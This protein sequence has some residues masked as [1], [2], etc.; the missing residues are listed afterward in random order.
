MEDLE[1]FHR[2]W[3]TAN[4][5][6]R[7]CLTWFVFPRCQN[8]SLT[9][10][11]ICWP[12]QTRLSRTHLRESN[13]V[14]VTA[15]VSRAGI[16]LLSSARRGGQEGKWKLLHLLLAIAQ[17]KHSSENEAAA[18]TWQQEG[19]PPPDITLNP[20]D[21]TPSGLLMEASAANC[22]C[23]CTRSEERC[24]AIKAIGLIALV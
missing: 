1:F 23:C 6:Q 18:L 10:S 8:S 21:E 7:R 17:R 2:P 15:G 3:K 12:E 13:P 16:S 14:H 9:A 5:K 22:C 4:R 20:S 19:A 24:V 11:D